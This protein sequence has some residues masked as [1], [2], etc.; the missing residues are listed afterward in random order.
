MKAWKTKGKFCMGKIKIMLVGVLSGFVNGLLG[1]GGGIVLV[2]A[3]GRFLKEKEGKDIFAVT[4]TV[5]MSMSVVSAIVYG[6]NGGLELDTGIRY[7]VAAI[8]GGI[9]GAYLLDKLKLE[10]IKKVFGV[11]VLWVGLNM[12]GVI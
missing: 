7:G 9:I 12:A 2:F 10:T 8:P 4:L 11:L 3:L 6:F 1:T 5:T